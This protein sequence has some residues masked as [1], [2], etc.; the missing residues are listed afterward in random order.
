MTCLITGCDLVDVAGGR[1]AHGDLYKIGH[2]YVFNAFLYAGNGPNGQRAGE[3]A[4]C[5]EPTKAGSKQLIFEGVPVLG[6]FFERRGVLTFP[7][8]WGRL[9]DV[10][11]AYLG[12]LP[13]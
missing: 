5:Y 1:W 3:T 7:A 8:I 6:D 2:N 9:N 4:W 12:R 13:T 10:A 11:A